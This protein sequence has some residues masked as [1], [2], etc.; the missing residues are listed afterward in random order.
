MGAEKSGKNKKV[1]VW[2]WLGTLILMAIPG[3]NLIA[4]ILF[5][6]FAKA[7][8]KRSYC[9]AVLILWL[10]G[11]VLVAAAFLIFPDQLTQLADYMRQT[12]NEPVVSL[13]GFN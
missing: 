13:P 5:L 3:V 10:L 9:I 8:A 1:S 2:N 7:Q 12:A 6:I 11:V 4:L